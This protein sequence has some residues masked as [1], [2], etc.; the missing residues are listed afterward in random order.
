P[1]DPVALQPRD[2]IGGLAEL[3]TVARLDL[4]EDDR[5]AVARDDVNFSTTRAVAP[6]KYCVPATRQLLAR[7][8]F[9]GFSKG[10][11]GLRHDPHSSARQRPQSESP[12][13]LRR[14]L[15]EAQGESHGVLVEPCG[16]RGYFRDDS[17]SVSASSKIRTAVSA[18]SRVR[19]SGGEK[20]TAFFP[21]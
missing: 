4:D 6:G 7:E 10:N 15:R 16:C 18:S 13:A 14:L 8:I 20:R 3:V 21:A 5:P 11:A 12:R 1:G 19:T 2:R 17:T 9:A